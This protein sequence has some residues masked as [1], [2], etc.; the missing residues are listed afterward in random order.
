MTELATYLQQYQTYLHECC[1]LFY[2]VAARD[3]AHNYTG[4]LDEREYTRLYERFVQPL[5]Q[6]TFAWQSYIAEHIPDDVAAT[7]LALLA[8]AIAR[9]EE[10]RLR[11]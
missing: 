2:Y 1:S 5:K 10:S 6:W 11:D 3:A 7:N 8:M 9:I 4:F